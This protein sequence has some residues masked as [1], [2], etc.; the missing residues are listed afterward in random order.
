MPGVVQL[1]LSVRS[2]SELASALYTKLGF[3][4][5]GVDRRSICCGGTY[6]DENRMV[7]MLDA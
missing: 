5:T 7:L 4:F 6:Y 2:V 3:E 1:T